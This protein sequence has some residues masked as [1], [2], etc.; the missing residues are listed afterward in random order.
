MVTSPVPDKQRYQFRRQSFRTSDGLGSCYRPPQKWSQEYSH[1]YHCSP[2]QYIL[3]YIYIYISTCVYI[4]IYIAFGLLKNEELRLP[5][6]IGAMH[7]RTVI[8]MPHLS[9]H[10]LITWQWCPGIINYLFISDFNRCQNLKHWGY[11]WHIAK[12]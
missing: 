5:L 12:V 9:L 2:S 7:G 3:I 11:C 8:C 6:F 10:T 4:Y 1:C